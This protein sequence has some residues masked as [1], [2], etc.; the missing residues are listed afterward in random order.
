MMQLYVAIKI[1]FT[2]NLTTG[3]TVCYKIKWKELN[4]KL[5]EQHDPNYGKKYI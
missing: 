4:T 2:N 3:E 5:E 1:V